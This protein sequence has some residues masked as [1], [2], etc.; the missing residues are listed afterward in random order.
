MP[1][2]LRTI[3]TI[4]AAAGLLVLAACRP[5][6]ARLEAN[7][8][9]LVIYGTEQSKEISVRAVDAKGAS[10]TEAPPLKWQSSDERVVTVSSGGHV[11][12][13]QPGKATVTVSSGPLSASVGV[14]VV[15]LSAIELAP[16]LLRLVGPPGTTARFVVTG[17]NAAKKPTP[18]PAVSW[19]VTNPQVATVARDGTVT[20]IASGRTLV[21][22]KVGDLVAES[23]L[24]IDVRNVSRIELRPETAILRVGESQKLSVTAYDENGL[25]I[26]DA[27]AQLSASAPD[28]VRL[29]GDG[30]VTGL[31]AG[32]AVITASVGDRRAEATVLVD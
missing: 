8:R 2:G 7:P 20:S 16:A 10:V 6:V 14:E 24:Q 9:R 15:D 17:R 3:G 21:T 31:K 32:T 11:V 19:L 28:V 18:V 1:S 4:A 25:P 23:E 13:K 30:T 27:G 26:P 22:A 12:P 29:L 5:K